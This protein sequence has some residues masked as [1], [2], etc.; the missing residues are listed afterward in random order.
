MKITSINNISFRSNVTKK[1]PTQQNSSDITTC[2]LN[3]QP[4]NVIN[5]SLVKR[6]NV[7]LLKPKYFNSNS[8]KNESCLSINDK[9][10]LNYIQENPKTGELEFKKELNPEKLPIANGK[11]KGFKINHFVLPN[12]SIA[13]Q[14]RLKTSLSTASLYQCIAVSF[15]DRKSNLQSLLHLC[16]LI[17]KKANTNLLKYLTSNCDKDNLE[18]SIVHG[19]DEDTDDAITFLLDFIKENCP[20]AQVKFMDYPEEGYDFLV[21]NNGNL[22]VLE[23]YQDFEKIAT[24]P[25]KRIIH[26]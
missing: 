18:I 11:F 19:C 4:S 21:L 14:T 3:R 24:N 20:N 26:A 5:Q 9:R 13:M 8:P 12:G 6:K 10:T 15:V 7:P 17:D 25:R 2:D 23:T 22:Q 16:P 1:T